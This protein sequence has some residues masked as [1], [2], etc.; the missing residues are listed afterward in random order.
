MIGHELLLVPTVSVLPWDENGRL[1]LARSA[2]SGEWMTIGGMVE[3]DEAP[4]EAA[5]REAREEAGV[6]LALCGIRAALGGPHCRIRY[7]NGDE[8]SVV[9]IVF[10]ARIVGGSPGADNVE[11]SELAWFSAAEIPKLPMNDFTTFKFK[12]LGLFDA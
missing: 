3:P 8:V 6:E 12:S 10:D 4:Q 11:T 1:L 7:P 5:I 2:L 9:N